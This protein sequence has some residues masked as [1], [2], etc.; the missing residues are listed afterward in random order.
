[1]RQVLLLAFFGV[2]L[3]LSNRYFT[4]IDDEVLI[5]SAATRPVSATLE[6]FLVRRGT[7]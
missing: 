7:A 2:A 6:L 3:M 4:F 1:M 5:T